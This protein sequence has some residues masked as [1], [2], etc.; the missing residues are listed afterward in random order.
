MSDRA[1]FILG[2]FVILGGVALGVWQSA[3]T[4]AY[5]VA[6]DNF[7]ADAMNL[8]SIKSGL[9]DQYQ[10]IK[11]DVLSARVGVEQDLAF[12][13]PTEENISDL[14]RLL[15]DF[16]VKNNFKSNP[17]FI[18]S[19]SYQG[20]TEN[21]EGNYR[22]MPFSINMETSKSNMLEFLEFINDSG[23]LK[24]GVRLMS[25]EDLNIIYPTEYGGQY[26]VRMTVNAYFSREI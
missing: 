15:D 16:S 25:V 13:F 26:N 4:K 22:V 6:I 19:V 9:I 23:S 11:V 3:E 8:R 12:V 2:L 17:F 24:S 21:E 14:N 1:K 7:N 10:E 18:S 20:V 5:Q